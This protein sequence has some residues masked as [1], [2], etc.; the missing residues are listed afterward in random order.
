MPLASLWGGGI[1]CG[2]RVVALE[3][4]QAGERTG[5]A[6]DEVAGVARWDGGGAVEGR[7]AGRQA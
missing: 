3:R 4:V 6:A 2:R 7:Q 5:G 1:G